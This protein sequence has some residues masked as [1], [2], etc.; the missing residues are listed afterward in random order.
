M[1]TANT[2]RNKD[3]V[4]NDLYQT[5]QEAT[6]LAINAGIFD[7]L[8]TIYD[9]CNGKGALSDV[10]QKHVPVIIKSDLIDYD[11]P[12]VDVFDY[13]KVDT[14]YGADALVMNPPYRLTADFLDKACDEYD[15]VIMF[16]RI[17]FLETSKRAYKMISGD[18]PLTEV[19]I[20]A[21]RV[22]CYKEEEGDTPKAVMYAWYVFD[23]KVWN[24]NHFI[25]PNVR[26]LMRGI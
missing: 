7:D 11:I 1:A 24:S 9:P 8:I 14:A 17:S 19:Y 4:E 23:R 6:I 12:Y 20:H 22:G 10:L 5:S 16:N 25:A 21:D 15:K 2:R 26:W 3:A 13:L 18:W